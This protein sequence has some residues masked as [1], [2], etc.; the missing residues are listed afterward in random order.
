MARDGRSG[1]TSEYGSY[2]KPPLGARDGEELTGYQVVTADGTL[3]G[4][5]EG[6]VEFWCAGQFLCRDA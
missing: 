3:L 5:V 1:A 6:L 2:V 4:T